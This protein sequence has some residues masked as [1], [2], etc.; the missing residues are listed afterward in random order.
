MGAGAKPKYGEV[1]AVM[2]VPT[3]KVSAVKQFLSKQALVLYECKIEAGFP[4]PASDYIEGTLDLNDHLI[5]NPAATFFV[6]VSGESMVGA[7][8]RPND[9]LIVDR[10]INPTNGK[11][12]IAV[13]DGELTVKRLRFKDN[14]AYLM[15][16]NSSFRP[17]KVSPDSDF[18]IWGVVTNVIHPV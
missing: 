11:I 16:E 14:Q 2:R 3:S 15:P 9:I 18:S 6:R 5:K 17:I 10:S 12:V 4:S 13:L 1:T 8:M 7:G